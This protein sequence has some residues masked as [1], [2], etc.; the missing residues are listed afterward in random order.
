M[1]KKNKNQEKKL[2]FVFE[3]TEYVGKKGPPYVFFLVYKIIFLCSDKQRKWHN[4]L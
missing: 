2:R 4:E 1:K 3:R